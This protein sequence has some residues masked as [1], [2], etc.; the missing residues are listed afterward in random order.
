MMNIAVNAEWYDCGN[1][2][3][4]GTYTEQLYKHIWKIDK[5][6]NY[7]FFCRSPAKELLQLGLDKAKFK[8]TVGFE[9]NKYLKI[10]WENTIL[11][12][13]INR[14]NPVIFHS[15][16]YSLPLLL[17]PAIKKVATVYDLT[18]VKFPEFFSKDTL[19]VAKKRF[20]HTCRSAD[21]IIAISENTKQDILKHFDCEIGKIEV[22]HLGVEHEKF[23]PMDLDKRDKAYIGEKYSL[24]EKFI[25]WLGEFR[26]N[27]N[28][29]RLCNS[30]IKAKKQL[31]F[32]HKLVLC[33]HKGQEYAAIQ[34]IIQDHREFFIFPGVVEDNDLPLLY[35]LA[36]IFVF[37]S[38]YEGF[39]LPV[40]EAMACGTPVITSNCSSLPEVAGDA[41]ILVNPEDEQE[42]AGAIMRLLTDESLR[43]S[44]VQKGLERVKNFSWEK[45]AEKTL[46]L[47]KKVGNKK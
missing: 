42:I 32:N 19:Y 21:K 34:T 37:P 27:K 6:H 12:F 47:F 1:R 22:I 20:Q 7:T 25:L 45:T 11:P 29:K 13:E 35:N 2:T 3:G 33:G 46:E 43:N 14:I 40:L 4:I 31:H 17:R 9:T 41:A 18:W 24:P 23:K 28:I 26:G 8:P 30:L 39:G 16:N 10:I 38:L 44:L 5:D 15:V 36:D